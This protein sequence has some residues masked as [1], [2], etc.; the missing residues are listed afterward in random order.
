MTLGNFGLDLHR[1]A[2]RSIVEDLSTWSTICVTTGRLDGLDRDTLYDL[3]RFSGR[4]QRRSDDLC[5]LEGPSILAWLGDGEGKGPWI[6]S[7]F[8]GSVLGMHDLI[9]DIFN[10]GGSAYYRV[11]GLTLGINNLPAT[12]IWA[13]V[14]TTI[15]VK[16]TR[17][18]LDEICNLLGWY[19]RCDPD[20]SF[21]I[22]D[23]TDIFVETPTM[24]VVPSWWC[25]SPSDP[26]LR[27]VAGEIKA[28]NSNDHYVSDLMIHGGPYEGQAAVAYGTE[29][30]A[31][32]HEGVDQGIIW[33]NVENDQD[34]GSTAAADAAADKEMLAN[35]ST[36]NLIDISVR[37]DD[38]KAHVAPG[39]AIYVCDPRQG[40]VLPGLYQ[41]QV[42]GQ[43]LFPIL[44]NVQEM[45]WP[46][47]EGMGVYAVDNA[48]A[49][50]I[51]LSDF[52][53]WG[54]GDVELKV[55]ARW[56]TPAEVVSGR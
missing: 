19:Y 50:V 25:E 15:P 20:G 37:L 9:D 36:E 28:T 51:D 3:S 4:L 16:V 55:G 6:N 7:A 43:V 29:P 31:F 35:W 47:V 40:L 49:E 44:V 39:D 1:G 42:L 52:V 22:S 2:P 30:Y 5:H 34:F 17:P 54:D 8:D 24:L 18:W 56:P 23:S 21:H 14:D 41:V 53:I 10:S 12:A 27:V 13:A 46:W 33:Q 38:P 26:T 45:T 11:N 48:T 32:G